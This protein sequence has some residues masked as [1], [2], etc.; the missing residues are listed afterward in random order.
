[1]TKKTLSQK[2]EFDRLLHEPARLMIMFVLSNVDEV[3]FLFLRQETELTKGNLS[4]HL[5]RLED[6]GMILIR[7]EFQG[8]IPQTIISITN[9]GEIKL[10]A[11]RQQMQN[12][13][14]EME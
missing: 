6:A 2:F 8:R 11:Y 3:D 7:K 9:D 5:T 10:R 14:K 12:I 13:L 1:M 4:S